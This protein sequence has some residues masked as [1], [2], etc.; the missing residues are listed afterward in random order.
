MKVTLLPQAQQD[1]DAIYD[2]VL[3]R[4]IRALRLLEKFPEMGAPMV[5]PFTGYRSTIVACSG[6]SFES[7]RAAS[8]RSPTS[9]IAAAHHRPDQRVS[10]ARWTTRIGN[11]CTSGTPFAPPVLF[12]VF[13]DTIRIS[14]SS[15]APTRW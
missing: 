11:D 9:A 14:S 13:H 10:V 8:S 15:A 12:G 6:S 5:G 2:P 1:L 4:I 3:G 7:S